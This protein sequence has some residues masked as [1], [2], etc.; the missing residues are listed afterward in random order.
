MTSPAEPGK[1]YAIFWHM[2][3]RLLPFVLRRSAGGAA[4]L[5]LMALSLAL[6][7]RDVLLPAWPDPVEEVLAEAGTGSVER[8][9]L[10]PGSMGSVEALVVARS[11][12]ITLWRLEADSGHISHAWLAGVKDGEGQLLP[13]LPAW[14]ET[15]RLDGPLPSTARLVVITE[16]RESL[17]VD[18]AGIARMY[19]PNAMTLVQRIRLWRDRLG[20]RWQW[21]VKPTADA[22]M[23]PPLR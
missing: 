12:P 8:Q 21:P 5:L 9:F 4:L 20:E 13:A 23:T 6:P 7:A 19:R 10:S 22:Q 17:E 15:V 2:M 18:G 16:A 1:G 11:R 14:L 3:P